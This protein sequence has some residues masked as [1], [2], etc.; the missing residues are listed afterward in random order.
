M[1]H[2]VQ[3][4]LTISISDQTTA[5]TRWAPTQVQRKQE[6]GLVILVNFPGN[7]VLDILVEGIKGCQRHRRQALGP[8]TANEKQAVLGDACHHSNACQFDF[9]FLCQGQ[10]PPAEGS[11]CL[12]MFMDICTPGEPV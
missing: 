11:D 8:V 6:V 9:S 5:G 2:V 7:K 10:E 3:I 1:S 4:G 12:C